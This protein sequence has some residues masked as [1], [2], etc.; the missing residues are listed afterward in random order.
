MSHIVTVISKF[1][2]DNDGQLA[3]SQKPNLPIIVWFISMLASH[4]L[5]YGQ[6]NF[7]A[8]L[9][10]FGALFT[11]SWLEIFAGDSYF[12]RAL[13]LVVMLALLYSRL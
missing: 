8:N 1:F 3:I 5:P 7:A 12:R 4:F 10:A 11:W 13:G 9:I 2:K 6:L